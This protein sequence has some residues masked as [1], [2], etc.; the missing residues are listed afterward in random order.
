[1]KQVVR[2]L[3][4][5]VKERVVKYIL[6]RRNNDGGYTS[7][8]FVDSNVYDTYLALAILKELNVEPPEI[9][10]T[11]VWLKE[12]PLTDLR[13]IYY[14]NKSLE[15][16]NQPLVDAS[17]FIMSLRNEEGGFGSLTTFLKAS[18][19]V[20]EVYDVELV[21]G[22]E[23]TMMSVEL[24][25]MLKKEFD[26]EK[27]IKFILKLKNGDGGFGR[28]NFSSIVSTYHAIRTL[29]MLNYNIENLS[30]TLNYI[31][32]CES[33]NGGFT[34]APGVEPPF[35]EF[36][37]AG[38]MSLD[39][40]GRNPRDIRKTVEF[41]YNCMNSNG[42]FRRSMEHGISSF[43]NTYYAISILKKFGEIY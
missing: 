35:M 11:I 37:Y 42:G 23:T 30:D 6:L 31:E 9:E 24:L 36:T 22:L 17:E 18:D 28:R 25:N 7:V 26:K 38:V 29:K 33:A 40:F 20:E 27:T 1:M 12:Y 32:R 2:G 13:A 10:K 4:E 21:S 15:L 39:L 43:E 5:E 34:V 16:L 8:Q 19:E 41:V 3:E 14:I